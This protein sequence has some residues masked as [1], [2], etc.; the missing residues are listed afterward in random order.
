MESGGTGFTN[1]TVSFV[2]NDGT[3]ND[4][5]KRKMTSIYDKL[6]D[7]YEAEKDTSPPGYFIGPSKIHGQGVHA[8]KWLD[9]ELRVGAATSPYPEVTPMGKKLNHSSNPNCRLKQNGDG[10]DLV[11]TKGIDQGDELTVDYS[12]YD[13]FTDPDPNW[14]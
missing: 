3:V 9:P 8:K 12:Q 5:R 4:M 13:E 10:H 11:T 14:N 1:G 2:Q 6:A 7:L